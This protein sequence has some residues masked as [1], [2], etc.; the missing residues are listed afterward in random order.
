MEDAAAHSQGHSGSASSL[1]L[2]LRL[3]T[4]DLHDRLERAVCLPRS[5]SECRN[6][7]ARFY[8]FISAWQSAVEPL[9]QSVVHDLPRR[10]KSRTLEADLKYLGLDDHALAGVPRCPRL[11]EL[12]DADAA[13]GSMYVMEGST[14]GGQVIAHHLEANLGLRDGRGYSYFLSY[15]PE[16]G[17]MWRRFLDVLRDA[18]SPQR[19]ERI[20]AAAEQ[21]FDRLYD[22]FSGSGITN[23]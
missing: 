16:V 8:G 21:T 14:L 20:I 2:R 7:L 12:P 10:R 5:L 11:P 15:G 3:H 23:G 4:R 17:R 9:L 18:S 22:W 1:P 19:D 13:L 6:L